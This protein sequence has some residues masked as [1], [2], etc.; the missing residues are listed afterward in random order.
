MIKAGQGLQTLFPKLTHVTCAAHGLHRVAEQVRGF[1]P[2]VDALVSN[3]KKCF[4]K[5]PERITLF[6]EIAPDTPLPPE[7][8]LTRWATWIRAVFYYKEHYQ[9][10]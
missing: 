6:R 3:V 9:K 5:A 1:F 2:D 10:V 8:I 4:V 7:P